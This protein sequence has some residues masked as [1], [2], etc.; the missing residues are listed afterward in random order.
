MQRRGA[1]IAQLDRSL[2][3]YRQ[4]ADEG[5][6]L[7]RQAVAAVHDEISGIHFRTDKFFFALESLRLK[8]DMQQFTKIPD[9]SD[10]SVNWTVTR[11]QVPARKQC[12]FLASSSRAYV[13]PRCAVSGLG[14]LKRCHT[15]AAATLLIGLHSASVPMPILEICKH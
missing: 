12:R 4:R 7:L 9:T 13:M 3:L 14:P 6:Q 2:E 1:G 15:A 5:R 10:Q 8:V 11:S